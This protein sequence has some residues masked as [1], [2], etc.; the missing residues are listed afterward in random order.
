[1]RKP[2]RKRSSR[3]H[4]GAAASLML[5]GCADYLT[6]QDGEPRGP[7]LVTK[8]TLND[9]GLSRASGAVVTDTS[10]P[11][12]CSAAAAAGLLQCIADPFKDRY[13][14]RRSPPNPDSANILRVVFNK[15]PLNFKGAPLEPVPAEGLPTNATPLK[16]AEP[17]V[18]KL[19]CE[20]CSMDGLGNLGVPP[21]YNSLQLTG[22]DLSPNPAQYAY[23]PGLQMEV[24]AICPKEPVVPPPPAPPPA[25]T[26]CQL[27]GPSYKTD[28]FRALE[29]GAT[30][31]VILDPLLQARRGD[32][33]DNVLLDNAA[34]ALLTFTTEPFQVLTVGI[35]DGGDNEVAG[36]TDFG[37]GS[38]ATPY[39]ANLAGGDP[40]LA[41]E[42]A[43]VVG[44]NAPAD[45][46]RFTVQ[47]VSAA[48]T[49][50]GATMAVPVTISTALGAAGDCDFGNRR[51]LYIAPTAG[52]WLAMATPGAVVTVTIRG[53]EIRDL[54]QLPGHPAGQGV[55]V[56]AKDITVQA[57]LLPESIPVPAPEPDPY[58]GVRAEL[59]VA[60][61]GC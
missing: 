26:K 36:T 56:L 34:K 46:S 30:Y 3:L 11:P 45:E 22:T 16:L 43:L 58:T 17:G 32:G 31:S 47:T 15:A 55:H 28:P 14:V 20:N 53:S 7:L 21:S 8:L 24:I 5:L 42:G 51:L 4:A 60:P 19:S 23:G 59:V 33:T 10:V 44:L 41:N 6:G 38:T 54:S 48:V 40:E 2:S 12:D 39:Q 25:P 29:P 57:K 13:G 27:A 18:L 49:A 9:S 52:S 37:D 50:N 35:G 61:S 1:M